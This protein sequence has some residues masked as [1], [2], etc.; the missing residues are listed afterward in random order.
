MKTKHFSFLLGLALLCFLLIQNSINAQ[1]IVVTDDDSYTVE[2]SAMLDVK[3]IDKGLLI[4]RLDSSQRVGISSPATGLLV[5][6]TDANAFYYYDGAD[7]LNLTTNVIS[8]ASASVD[9]ALFSVV[10]T[11]GDTVFAVYPEGVEVN[12]GDGVGKAKKGGFAIGGLASGKLPQ[13]E[14]F[15]VTADSVRVYVDTTTGTK[16]KKG[17]FAIGGLAS[18]KASGPT[19]FTV[20]DDSVRVYIDDDPVQG[21]K[22]GFAV[23]RV[24]G[25]KTITDDFLRV[26]AD[27][28][29]IY[30]ED[31]PT[32]GVK[33]GFAVGRV[34]GGKGNANDYL[35]ISSDTE[36]EVIDPS[37][38]R[39]LWYPKKEAFLTGKV[40]IEDADSVGTNSMA[41]G[42]ESKAIGDYSQALG[43]KARAVGNNS[44]AIGNFA[45]AQDSGS[46]AIGSGAT[47]SGLR[48]FAL[49]STGV[50]SAGIPTSPTVANGN[51]AYAIGM[52]SV[53]SDSGAFALGT[54]NTATGKYSLAMGYNTVANYWYSTAMG[55]NTEA[56]GDFCT[57]MGYNT[58]ATGKYSTAMGRQ[59]TASNDGATAMGYNTTASG[60][61]STAM[62]NYSTASGSFSTAI[63]YNTTASGWFSTAF[64]QEIEAQ[65]DYSFAI[66]LNDQNGTVVSQANTMAIMGGNVG[67][68]TASPAADLE[69]FGNAI[70]G[71]SAMNW[72]TVDGVLELAIRQ[73]WYFGQRG[74]GGNSHLTLHPEIDGTG[75]YIV[76]ED[77]SGNWVL[78]V[79]PSNTVVNSQ[80]IMIPNGGNVGIGTST[81][82]HKLDIQTDDSTGFAAYFFNDGNHYDRYGIGIQAGLDGGWAGNPDCHLV[83]A[84]DGDATYHGSL[85]IEASNLALYQSSDKRL[86]EN[87]VKTSLSGMNILN[88]IEVVDFNFKRNPGTKQTGYIAQD[89]E[90]VFP[91]M[92]GYDEETD[93]Y[94]IATAR[95]IPVL[96]QGIKELHATINKQQQEI[97]E[98]KQMIKKM[99]GGN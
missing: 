1:N 18:G 63:G 62:G 37:E 28:V 75:F 29:R 58:T 64:G 8:P 14:F 6:D 21:V 47:A 2:S 16:A 35:K 46:Y 30:I 60:V 74:T 93:T 69:V 90:K 84:Y 25:G 48:S 81:P 76:P 88:E 66:A 68:G 94:L 97:D 38:A 33:G 39:I 83:R 80:I 72:N 42:F 92:V 34:T 96:H 85:A 40:L 87:L 57:A 20:S 15:R 43:Y 67:I 71:I 91:D 41:T 11:N 53:A 77:Q 89:V 19:F 9:D 23:G 50:D 86:K 78:G 26:S 3:S 98:L 12:V 31:S 95:L 49:G 32:K 36:A 56:N 7:W 44:T 65:G 4:P 27:S 24:T 99:Q 17:G 54:Q 51:Y 10:N 82:D 79:I 13:A 5:F 59:T 73:P 45:F 22:G 61:S 55:Y 70:I 52:G